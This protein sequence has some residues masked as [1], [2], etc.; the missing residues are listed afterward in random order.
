MRFSCDRAALLEKL[1]VL[2]RGVSSRSALP[3]LSGVLLQAREGRLDLFSTD[4]ELSIKAT[5]TTA[6]NAKTLVHPDFAPGA[7]QG[8]A[9]PNFGDGF[10]GPTPDIGAHQR[11]TP[12]MQFGV[13]VK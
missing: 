4:M 2:A 6:H 10:T 9:I 11:G 13:G 12:P 3:V 5:V 8:L 7:G 1:N